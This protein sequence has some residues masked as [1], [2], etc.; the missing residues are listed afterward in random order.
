MVKRLLAL[1]AAALLMPGAGS[2]SI[3]WRDKTPGQKM[4]KNYI[5]N[6]N[7]FLIEQGEQE[8]NTCFEM[9][10]QLAVLGITSAPNAETPEGVEITAKLYYDCINS[11]EVRVD[12]PERFAG[13]AAAFLRALY[14]ETMSAEQAIAAPAD[15]MKLALKNPENSFAD[16]VEE[17]N[18]TSPRTYY[19]YLPDQYHDGVNWMQM[20]IIFPLAGY[21]EGSGI[22]DGATPT[23]APD[24]TSDHDP[25]YE[26]YYSMDPYQHFEF[27]VTPTPE[28]DSPAGEEE[29]GKGAFRSSWAAA[30]ST[31]RK[32]H[33]L[34]LR[35]LR[36]P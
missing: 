14:P 33:R 5:E 22:I 21:W 31:L 35:A 3:A 36:T 27:F 17:L 20:T 16:A 2:A 34:F 15:R 1:L 30:R 4:L 19:A 12:E 7:T 8:I 29:E 25:E 23:K 6:V 13:I 26:G 32:S 18:G 9:Y 11:V 10:E 28:P 24:T